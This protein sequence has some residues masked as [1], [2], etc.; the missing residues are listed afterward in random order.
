MD[1]VTIDLRGRSSWDPGA[2]F[3]EA[4]SW[5]CDYPSVRLGDIASTFLPPVAS[6]DDGLVVTPAGLDPRTGG[7]R[8]R[9]NR[10][11][12]DVYQ[13]GQGEGG[14]RPGDLLVPPSA[15]QPVLYV[16]EDLVGSFVASAFTVLRAPELGAWIWGVLN[17]A[18][19]KRLRAMSS[20]GRM[21]P[22]NSRVRVLDL[23]V[24]V[25]PHSAMGAV[26]PEL[27]SLIDA[28]VGEEEE[29]A[30]S[31]WRAADLRGTEWRFALAT[32]SPELLEAGVPLE[33]LA[34]EIRVGSHSARRLYQPRSAPGDLPVADM[35]WLR[36]GR[37][38]SWFPFTADETVAVTN[39]ADVLIAVYGEAALARVVPAGLVIDSTVYA[40]SLEDPT[41]GAGLARYLNGRTGKGARTLRLTGSTAPRLSV[42]DVRALNVTEQIYKF[43][44]ADCEIDAPL[45]ER[46]ETLLW[47]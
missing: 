31:W 24:P 18:S 13:V 21:G 22:A 12:G 9:S 38:K 14:V 20:A 32:P 27:R 45:E 47:T 35:A 30:T 5:P 6:I 3:V 37:V 42:R 4:F 33:S 29:A 43:G 16:T 25:P 34:R 26:A 36:A 44:A 46:L 23:H 40:L 2:L 28:S 39:E 41:L 17:S 10:H 15:T 8:Q 11:L 19:G 1:T 7:I